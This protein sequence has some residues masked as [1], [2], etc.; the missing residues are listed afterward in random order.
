[1]TNQVAAT[2]WNQIS[3]A[4][5]MACGAR[6]PSAGDNSLIFT[7]LKD[8]LTKVKVVLDPTDTYTVQFIKIHRRT[9]DIAVAEQIEGVYADQLSNVV[10][11]VCNK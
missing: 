10:Y 4:T 1:M 8:R 11:G 3:I 2:I 9:H 6:E 5:K 7:V